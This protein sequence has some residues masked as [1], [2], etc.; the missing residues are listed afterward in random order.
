MEFMS[1]LEEPRIAFKGD[2]CKGKAGRM[3]ETLYLVLIDFSDESPTNQGT[4]KERNNPW[5][6]HP[7]QPRD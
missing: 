2:G 1:R 6:I 7:W 5:V 4:Q 3:I